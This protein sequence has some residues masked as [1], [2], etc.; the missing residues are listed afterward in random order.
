VEA[1]YARARHES[2]RVIVERHVE[3]REHRLL[4]V[5]GRLLSAVRPD[6]D[7]G[8]FHDLTD[9]VHAEVRERARDAALALGLDIAEVHLVTPDIAAPLE[10]CG[11]AVIEVNA[12]PGLRI[13]LGADEGDPRGVGAAIL[14]TVLPAGENGRIPIAA[15][16][17]ANGKTTV[18]RFI[19]HLLRGVHRTVGM[20]CTD[21]IYLNDRRIESGDCSGPIS[22]G[23][24]LMNRGVEAAVFET[25][26]GGVLRAGLGF[27][28]CAVAVVTNVGDGD[29]LGL[30]DI[31][32]A[33]DLAK[34]KRT[35]VEVT[36]RDGAAVLNAADP[37]VVAM[38]PYA[39]GRV[40]YFAID[41]ELPVI[42]EHSAGGGQAVF[43]RGGA[44]VFAV[45]PREEPW[46][47]LAQLPLT[48]GGDIGFE[49]ENALAALAA[50]WAL[51]VPRDVLVERAASFSTDMSMSPGRFNVL[52]VRG[53]AVIVDYGHNAHSLR[54][55]IASFRH[56]P[57]QRRTVMY[58][59][60]GDR[61]DSDIVQIGELIGDHFDRVIL[62][63][64]HTVRGRA[65]GS[66]AEL[67]RQGILRS[68]RTRL[69]EE[70][71]GSV[72]S[73]EYALDTLEPGDLLLMQADVIDETLDWV[74][75]YLDR[76]ARGGPAPPLPAP[77]RV[78]RLEPHAARSA[79]SGD[80]TP[81]PAAH[82]EDDPCTGV[83][84]GVP[85]GAKEW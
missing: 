51:G 50:G 35:I 7:A 39:P 29:H 21:G 56:F 64:A 40:I 37:L 49:V 5:Q 78:D 74:R 46:I 67:M 83:L 43:V 71:V 73:M 45:G 44:V 60:A 23:L 36:A 30:N 34:V 77:V 48:F 9:H 63:E 19:A 33:E 85:A 55:L 79:R 15:V 3:G 6:R 53:G 18:T 62:Y 1:A 61:R 47:E 16:S 17:G 69:I 13:Y 58:T 57:H 70:F 32:T 12:S 59:M 42:R 65:A 84:A 82:C 11:G 75:S 22:A 52:E 8:A 76:L 68:S 66:I 38:A 54:A 72:D 14:E 41:G 20:T 31:H 26:R 2:S 27:D 4:M 10:A 24:V 28:E 25:A 81:A 80:G